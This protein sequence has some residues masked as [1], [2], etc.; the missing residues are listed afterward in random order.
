M[1]DEADQTPVELTATWRALICLTFLKNRHLMRCT[2]TLL[3]SKMCAEF[4]IFSEEMASFQKDGCSEKAV[5]C[6]EISSFLVSAMFSRVRLQRD[7]T[8]FLQNGDICNINAG[9]DYSKF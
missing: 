4:Q 5:S 7:N 1:Y 2:L 6:F 8:A 3:T 9:R